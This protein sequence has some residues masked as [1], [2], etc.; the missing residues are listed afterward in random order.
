MPSGSPARPLRRLRQRLEA[1]TESGD[2]T[3]LDPGEFSSPIVPRR[4]SEAAANPES[5][6]TDLASWI[7]GT[8]SHPPH[9]GH[10]GRGDFCR[11]RALLPPPCGPLVGRVGVAGR[12]AG[13]KRCPPPQTAPRRGPAEDALA[14]SGV[15]ASPQGPQGGGEL[16]GT[17]GNN[18]AFRTSKSVSQGARARNTVRRTIRCDNLYGRP[19]PPGPPWRTLRVNLPQRAT[20]DCCTACLVG[21]RHRRTP[22]ELGV[23]RSSRIT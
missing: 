10:K 4:R 6:N 15:P 5:K 8:P 17:P 11:A 2:S 23:V 9:T 12:Q 18:R 20:A 13:R 19:F 21:K 16:E 7:A 1:K 22:N 3:K 14:F